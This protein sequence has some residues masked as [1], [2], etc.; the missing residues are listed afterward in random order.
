MA[1]IYGLSTATLATLA[2]VVEGL[3]IIIS[4]VAHPESQPGIT[5]LIVVVTALATWFGINYKEK[6]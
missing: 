4:E 5:I 3:V 1:K 2:V 6:K